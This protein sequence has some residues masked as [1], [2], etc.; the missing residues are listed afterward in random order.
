MCQ[1]CPENSE[2][3]RRDNERGGYVLNPRTDYRD[4]KRSRPTVEQREESTYDRHVR[5]EE[6]GHCGIRMGEERLNE[7]REVVSVIIFS[8]ARNR[9]RIESKRG[10]YRARHSTY[11]LKFARI[12]PHPA[13]CISG[14]WMSSA[15]KVSV[16]RTPSGV[17]SNVISTS[18]PAGRKYSF[19][20][21]MV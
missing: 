20:S 5:H 11:F 13:I 3:S 21:P 17:S 16:T 9:K 19:I 15:S 12:A 6:C 1:I 10:F 4:Q 18:R 2:K 7:F 14:E 8:H